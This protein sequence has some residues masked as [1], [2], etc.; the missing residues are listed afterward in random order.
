MFERVLHAF[1]DRTILTACHRLSLV[2]AF[3]RIVLV[4]VGRIIE[5]GGF[6][7]LITLDGEFAASWRDFQRNGSERSVEIKT[8]VMV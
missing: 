1:K 5:Q 3:D 2:P 8:A 4:R 7:E 6:D